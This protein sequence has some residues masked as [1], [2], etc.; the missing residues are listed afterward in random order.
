VTF[1]ERFFGPGNLLRWEAIQTGT[2]RA[3]VRDR[4]GPF[5]E[6][7]QR[8]PE[9][10]VLPRPREN[11]LVHWYVLCSSARSARVAR[12]EVRAFLGPSYSDFEGQPSLLDTSDPVEAAVVERCGS[13]AFRFE[14][15][16]RALFPS[17]RERLSLLLRL[18]ENR[19]LRHA[20]GVRATGRVLRDFEYA[21]Q[22]GEGT[23]AAECIRELRA[24]GRLDAAN[25]LFLEVRR[26]AALQN[27]PAVLETPELR[28]LL[29]ILRPRRVTEVLIRAVYICH[30]SQFEKLGRPADAVQYFRSEVWP[31]FGD[32]YRSRAGLRGYGVDASF[33]LLG[34]AST[35]PRH[36]L[37]ETILADRPADVSGRSYLEA[38]AALLPSLRLPPAPDLMQQ[39]VQAF[40]IADVD[41]AYE[42]ADLLSPSFERCSLLL[43]CARD[44]GTLEAARAALAAVK[45]LAPSDRER[46]H[47][48]AVL[49]KIHERLALFA[50]GP[51]SEALPGAVSTRPDEVPSSWTM[52]LERLRRPERWPSALAVA[53][54]GAR[55]WKP[56]DFAADSRQVALTAD[57]LLA[58]RPEWGQAAFRN[59]LPH[60]L[61]FILSID[62]DRRLKPIY[63]S[64]FLGIAV[65]EQ[66]SL[67][68]LTALVRVAEARLTLGVASDE[69]RHTVTQLVLALEA[70]GSPSAI[71]LALEAVDML[72]NVPCPAPNVREQFLVGVDRLLLR[73]YRRIDPAQWALLRMLGEELGLPGLTSQPPDQEVQ[74]SPESVWLQ[75]EGKKIALYSLRE[76]AL[77]RAQSILRSLCPRLSIQVFHDKVG[78]SPALRTAAET[79]DLFVIA[80]GAAK[81]AATTFVESHR[82]KSRPTLYARSQG[83]ASLLGALRG[84]I[85]RVVDR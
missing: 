36:E 39:A 77:R 11:G 20:R 25:L 47:Q 80:T 82:P 23:T 55:E 37:V 4:L 10:L 67:A 71:D 83:T 1:E 26:L 81:H 19:P 9:V 28:V 62:P 57:L 61:E 78:G 79:V 32:L 50:T 44:M 16:D 54:V 33:M 70:V 3:D 35:P 58:S 38:I 72:V 69:Y 53:E 21:V 59:A 85:A 48:H 29:E 22:A 63:E 66:I 8:N 14:V 42:L 40:A 12:D 17:A 49:A 64:L 24:T 46:V 45:S 65:D 13:H 84:Y 51:A 30:L 68:Q 5:L 56:A 52:W 31:R 60:F 15:P 41:R 18:R 2:L 7:L 75:L 73:W 74:P 76:S 43:R 27:W 6:D 34:V